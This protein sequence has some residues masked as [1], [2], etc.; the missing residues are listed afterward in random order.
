MITKYTK[1]DL[2]SVAKDL[3]KTFNNTKPR[4][5]ARFSNGY[6]I[7]VNDNHTRLIINHM[8]LIA[9]VL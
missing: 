1:K 7:E 2:D 3:I 5:R 4:F 6:Y 9:T 8:E